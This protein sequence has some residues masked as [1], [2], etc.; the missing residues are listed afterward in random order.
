MFL[1]V[2]ITTTREIKK[3]H[4]V[5]KIKIYSNGSLSLEKTFTLHSFIILIK[6]VFNKYQ[7]HYYYDVFLEIGSYQLA[8]K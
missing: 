3:E 6:T 2:A 8:E 7:N 5:L 4:V 1:L